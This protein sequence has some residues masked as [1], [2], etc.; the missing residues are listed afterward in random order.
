MHYVLG[1]QKFGFFV[2]LAQKVKSHILAI[3][4]P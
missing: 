1:I 4:K 2:L 3:L